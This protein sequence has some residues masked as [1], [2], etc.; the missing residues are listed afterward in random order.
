MVRLEVVREDSYTKIS[1][2]QFLVVRLEV[3]FQMEQLPQHIKFQFLVV[4]L[5]VTAPVQ[6]LCTRH[7]FQF[8]VVRL[9]VTTRKR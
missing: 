3:C 9:E 4:R 5:E 8:L 6:Q 2:F 7:I 1:V